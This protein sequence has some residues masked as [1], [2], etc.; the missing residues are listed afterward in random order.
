LKYVG[1]KLFCAHKNELCG[2]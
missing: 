1:R 2:N